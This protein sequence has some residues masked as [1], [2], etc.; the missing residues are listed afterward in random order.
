[1]AVKKLDES[2][3]NVT[4]R[5]NATAPWSHD[6]K[7]TDPGDIVT[8]SQGWSPQVQWFGSGDCQSFVLATGGGYDP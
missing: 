2:H 7:H 6:E 3:R 1:M 4:C 5:H 8:V